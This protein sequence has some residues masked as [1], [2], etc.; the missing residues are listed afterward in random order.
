[1]SLFSYDL[2]GLFLC[3]LD[4]FE[5]IPVMYLLAFIFY[6]YG[7]F[8]V[9]ELSTNSF[10]TLMDGCCITNINRVFIRTMNV[11]TI[12][13]LIERCNIL[14][15]DRTHEAWNYLF[16]F[17]KAS[18]MKVFRKQN[19]SFSNTPNMIL[20]LPENLRT[21]PVFVWLRVAQSSLFIL[22]LCTIIWV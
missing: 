16:S 5:C 1:M 17:K 2:Q 21:L 18:T 10:W 12:M 19:Q 9:R 14:M 3:W 20:D 8:F 4:A 22:L 13:S 6:S 15:Y 7:V 11:E